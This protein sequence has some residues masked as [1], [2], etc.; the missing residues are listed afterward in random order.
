M[1]LNRPALALGPGPRGVQDARRW[2]SDVCSELGR[3]DLIECAQL[4]ISELVTNALLHGAAPIE[5][6]LRGTQDHPRIEVHVGKQVTAVH[7]DQALEAITITKDG[8]EWTIPCTGLFCFIGADPN[9]Q[10]LD[11]VICDNHGFVLTD[12][13]LEAV[14]D[15]EWSGPGRDPLPFETSV[16]GVFVAGDV[17]AESVKR[18]ASAVGEGAMA[19]MLVHRYLEQL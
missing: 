12:H 1:P 3:Q 17:R 16:P 2:V 4:G 14:L 11:G 8:G 7:G 18:V 9:S 10:W 6:R 13:Q 19:V 5:L 15:G